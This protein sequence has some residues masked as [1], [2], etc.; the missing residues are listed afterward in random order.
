MEV[1]NV[2]GGCAAGRYAVSSGEVVDRAHFARG[3]V[4]TGIS[5]SQSEGVDVSDGNGDGEFYGKVDGTI[6][7]R[8]DGRDDGKVGGLDDLAWA[9]AGE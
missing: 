8:V 1:Q 3:R 7:G 9:L 6:S 4:C 5:Y 2:L